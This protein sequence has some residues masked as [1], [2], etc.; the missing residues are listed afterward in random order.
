MEILL[1]IIAHWYLSLF[2]QTFYYH[3]YA[4]HKMFTMSK[5]WEKIFNI[6]SLIAIGSSYMSP[7]A[8][9]ILH[10]LH[11]AYADTEK[12]P[13]S[14]KYDGNVWAMMW[15]T[16]IIY[17]DIFTGKATIEEKHKKEIPQW[18][19]FE[20]FADFRGTRLF[21][22][23]CYILFYIFFA[24]HWW[25]YLF[26][27]LHFVIGPVHGAIINW[28][29][30]KYGYVNFKL[31]DTSKNFLP[32]DFLMLGESYHNNHHKY[33]GRPNFG[34]KWFEMDP[35]YPVILLFDA[36]GIIKLKKDTAFA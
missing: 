10:R 4:A 9:G 33:G 30:H 36:L 8:Y 5:T 14:P 21:W 2:F 23:V 26:L 6:L 29:A 11:H 27:P 17:S 1:F 16:K 25:M 32:V 31:N 22:I 20:R 34:I 18:I 19:E 12:D 15:R 24:T 3:R 35:V 13:H 28:F 7:Y